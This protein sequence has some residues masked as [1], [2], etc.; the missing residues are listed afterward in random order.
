VDET[1]A[2]PPVVPAETVPVDPIPIDSW[3][4]VPIIP[5]DQT[6][7]APHARRHE[8]TGDD[9]IH[10]SVQ[11]SGVQLNRF[12]TLNFGAGLVATEDSANRRYNI[13]ASA[14]FSGA[15]VTDN[16]AQ[17]TSQASLASLAFNTDR[18]D[19]ANYHDTVTNNNRLTVPATGYYQIGGNAEWGSGALQLAIRLNGT[20]WIAFVD[21][22]TGT[23]RLAVSTVYLLTAGD[24]VELQ[25]RAATAST[26]VSASGNYSPEFWITRLG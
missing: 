19:T 23:V 1:E 14:V 15:R 3:P 12:R 13:A 8:L 24:Y 22:G 2:P 5:I 6:T 25:G 10:P 18:F 11:N 17:A 4:N 20:T 16:A 9:Q 7:Y 21:A 26:N